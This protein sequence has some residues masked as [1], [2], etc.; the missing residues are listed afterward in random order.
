MTLT[1]SLATLVLVA[2][3][4]AAV[5]A[6]TPARPP[7]TPA[8]APTATPPPTFRTET[9][10]RVWKVSVVDRDGKAVEGL[11]ANDFVVMEGGVRQE[12]AFATY[13]RL[14]PP[15]P[16]STPP[17]EI[18][19]AP[20]LDPVARTAASRITIPPANDTRFQDKR[21]MVLYFDLSRMPD[22]DKL[23]AFDAA[24]KYVRAQMGP[25]DVLAIMALQNGGV[26]IRQDF[27][28]DK[29]R[30]L[31]VL[32][33]MMFNDDFDQ[34][35]QPDLDSFASD[36]GQSA[37][38]NVFNTDRRLASL[39][40]AIS[41][42]RPL[43]QQKVLVYFGSGLNANGADNA[44]QYTSAVNAARRANVLISTIDTRGLVAVSPVG[45]ASRQSPGGM[46]MFNGS[47]AVS[48]MTGFLASQ[49]SLYAL[50]KDTGGKALLD[51]ND[52]TSGIVDA[53]RTATSYYLVA[54]Y[55]SNTAL[56]G[57]FRRVQVTVQG[58]KQYE[59]VA[60]DGYFA[61]KV[62]ANLNNSEREMQMQEAFRLENPLTDMTLAMELNYFKLNRAEYYVPITV[63]I[64]GSELQIA[65][66]RGA[67]R[68]EI[69]FMSEVKD[70]NMISYS[71][72]RDSLPITLS[73]D[74]ANQLNQRPILYQTG[75]TLL[76]GDYI[77]K[78]LARDTVTGR[79]GTFQAKFTVP[80]L[81]KDLGNV[82]ISTV[83]LSGQR[84]TVGSE[85][86]AVKNG[87][88]KEVQAV[89]P[90][91]HDGQR[92]IPSVTRVFS[93]GRDLFVYLQAYQPGATT[94]RPMMAFVSF[95]RNGEKV[96][97]TAP[98]SMDGPM[99]ARSKA[100]PMRFSLPI[101]KLEP[102]EYECQVTVLDPGTQRASFWRAPVTLVP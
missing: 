96:H 90:L 94:M 87:A 15:P 71:I 93:V 74:I 81:E 67:P 83:V 92:M 47:A 3:T 65:R 55:T 11:T 23:R 86:F 54:Y 56:D 36:F 13:Q 59:I 2:L 10:L 68:T 84:M 30:L 34:D 9:T 76:P 53:A 49:D 52:L 75:F 5:A 91:I 58:N 101:G 61:D 12:I 37:E 77:I 69:D 19:P 48:S 14:E 42:L 102:G 1:R 29:P 41:Y 27:T 70:N 64:P 7:Q 32:N 38:F 46:S 95:Y 26:K 51:N 6:Q 73:E 40:T 43:T 97:E 25:S 20:P 24:Q 62:W 60:Q 79:T 63:K 28:T 35:G 16:A 82:P 18:L 50:A 85:I 31:E 100:I 80:N 98:M 4:V 44:A 22:A 45:N 39:Q 89:D 17:A 8:Q 57:K 72:M 88:T 78:L 21:L 66:R 99:D 33:A